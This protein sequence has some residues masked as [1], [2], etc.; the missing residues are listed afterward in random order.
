M[1]APQPNNRANR[2][3]VA[4]MGTR[5]GFSLPPLAALLAADVEL[6]AVI[7]PG[8]T[9]APPLQPCRPTPLRSELP[10]LTPYL[11]PTIVEL[12]W[13][14]GI[15]VYA[16]TRR[17]GAALANWL[18]AQRVEVVCVAC[19]PWRIPAI[20]LKATPHGWLN[21][22]P[23][24]L[25]RHRGPA[26][27]FWTLH[28]GEREAGVTIHRMDAG[29]DHGPIAAQAALPLPDGISGP[30]LE[31]R[32]AQLGGRLL[33]ETLDRLRRGVLRYAPQASGG[34]YEAW[35]QAE[36]FTIAPDWSARR[37]FNF[38]RGTR[39][40][41]VPYRLITAA[42]TTLL[43]ADALGYNDYARLRRPIER[44]ADIVRVQLSPGVLTART[45]E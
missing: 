32:C 42:G 3:R 38:M 10:L 25:P 11:T 39:E 26:P 33:V 6:V 30:E 45:A 2:L 13:Q 23:S 35:P 31:Q 37:A 16:A 17:A 44:E 27:L 7:V 19:W 40:W 41:Q 28:A 9:D 36:D 24:R 34:S 1:D 29:L 4:F 22:H 5:G 8:Q 18:R 20:L 21:L 43:L 14:H 15:A 12:A